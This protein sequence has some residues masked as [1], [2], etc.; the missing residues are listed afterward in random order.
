[1]F[2]NPITGAKHRKWR[3]LHSSIAKSIKSTPPHRGKYDEI[4]HWPVE[5]AVRCYDGPLN[6]TGRQI[7]GVFRPS[8]DSEY[9][10][11]DNRRRGAALNHDLYGYDPDQG[12]AVIQARQAI[13]SKYGMSTRKTYF[14]C[15]QNEIT[16]EYFRHPV[17]A[18][19]VRAAINANPDPVRT[20]KAVQRWLWEVTETQLARSTRQG[21]ILLV[22]ECRIPNVP[23]QGTVLLV[24]GS[25]RIKADEIRIN[26]RCYA[27]NPT[28]VHTKGQHAT[29]VAQGWVS[30]RIAREAAAWDFAERIGD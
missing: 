21:D 22:P 7:V 18:H 16:G 30:I 25:H 23:S 8:L 15:G 1:M 9:C 11:F 2:T 12:V 4:T 3:V 17:S 19:A 6:F 26:G 13:G 20:V 24:S 29:K 28:V 10:E 27:L 14:L 5:T